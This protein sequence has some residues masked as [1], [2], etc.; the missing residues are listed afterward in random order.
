[1]QIPLIA[2]LYRGSSINLWFSWRRHSRTGVN[3]EGREVEDAT[4][5][6][7]DGNVLKPEWCLRRSVSLPL[8]PV[9]ISTQAERICASHLRWL[10]LPIVRQT[11]M[12]VSGWLATVLFKDLFFYPTPLFFHPLSQSVFYFIPIRAF[13]NAPLGFLAPVNLTR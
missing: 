2:S 6:Q 10:S 11:Q 9:T 7:R 1:M 3:Q 8:H 5:N 4:T 12:I 13:Q